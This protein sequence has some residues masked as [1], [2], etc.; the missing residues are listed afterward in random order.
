MSEHDDDTSPL[1]DLAHV[2]PRV[3]SP[4]D[5]GRV[6]QPVDPTPQDPHARGRARRLPSKWGGEE[7]PKLPSMQPERVEVTHNPMLDAVDPVTIPT[8]PPPTKPEYSRTTVR[9]VVHAELDEMISWGLPRFLRR[10]PRCTGEAMWPILALAVN[11]GAYYFCRTDN[12]CGLFVVMTS[13]EEPEPFVV[14]KF[15]VKRREAAD[16]EERDA[17]YRAGLEWA[18]SLNAVSYTFGS[19]TG[20]PLDGVADMIKPDITNHTYTKILR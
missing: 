6:P 20:V 5:A 2:A 16:N 7:Q 12:A 11:G 17:I 18:K 10:F 15:V 8:R 4:F 14:D 19:S 1:I 9:R 13:P 3:P